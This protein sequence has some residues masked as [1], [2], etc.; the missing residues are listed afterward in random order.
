MVDFSVTEIGLEEQILAVVV[1]KE[2]PELEKQRSE[3]IRIQN[4]STIHLKQLED[5]LLSRLASSSQAKVRHFYL[6]RS[7][8]STYLAYLFPFLFLLLTPHADGAVVD[9][10]SRYRAH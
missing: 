10:I 8:F 2:H 9:S 5:N 7:N 1:D 3:L 4:E 6:P